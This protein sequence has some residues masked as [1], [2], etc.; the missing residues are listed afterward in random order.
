M[1][2]LQTALYR[3][4]Q[5]FDCLR[6]DVSVIDYRWRGCGSD[7]GLGIDIFMLICDDERLRDTRVTQ[8]SSLAEIP[9]T[10]LAIGHKE[11]SA[12]M[13]FGGA[14]IVRGDNEVLFIQSTTG[15]NSLLVFPPAPDGCGNRCGEIHMAGP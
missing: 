11:Q 5:E 13:R 7:E 1:K 9:P 3:L 12:T 15:M 2:L 6:E 10:T 4:I 14:G 8:L